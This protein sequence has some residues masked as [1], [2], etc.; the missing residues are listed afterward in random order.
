MRSDEG[1]QAAAELVRAGDPLRFAAAMAAPPERRGALLAI[2][3][4]NLEIARAPWASSEPMVAEMRLQWWVDALDA[5]CDA[6]Q[7]PSHEIGPALSALVDGGLDLEP[8]KRLAEARRWDCWREPFDDRAAFERY[9]A[10]TSGSLYR[11]SVAALGAPDPA[12]DVAEA[13]G[14][15]AGLAAYLRAVPELEAR[16]RLPLPDGRPAAVAELAR[17]GLE[18]LAQ[19]RG[20]RGKVPG[21][22]VAAFLSGVDAGLI[23]RQ[24]RD[25][26]AR[27]AEGRLGGSEFSRRARVAWAGLT[28][29]W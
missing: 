16:G 15:A 19:A 24:A 26:P 23:L 28:G 14:C 17:A 10:A 11:L 4:L 5:L 7:A 25:D 29:R 6:G 3:A 21:Q 9:I 12:L 8:M 18:R 20:Q 27:V 13:F 2:Y 1:F 22:A